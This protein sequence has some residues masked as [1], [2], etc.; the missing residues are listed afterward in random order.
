MRNAPSYQDALRA[1]NR[2]AYAAASACKNETEKNKLKQ[3]CFETDVLVDALPSRLDDFHG[4]VP[5]I[6][7]GAR[8]R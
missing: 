6:A 4:E 8:F 2:A 5:A 7:H 3:I 1:L